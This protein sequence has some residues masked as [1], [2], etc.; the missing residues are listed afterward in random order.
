MNFQMLLSLHIPALVDKTEKYGDK[1]WDE[2]D[3][4]QRTFVQDSMM[5]CGWYSENDRSESDC[6]F[7]TGCSKI[8]KKM[9]VTIRDRLTIAW[10]LLFFVESMS[11]CILLLLRMKVKVKKNEKTT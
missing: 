6:K 11:I 10:V 2:L 7:T 9:A 1:R 4:L 5:C 8:I 3:P